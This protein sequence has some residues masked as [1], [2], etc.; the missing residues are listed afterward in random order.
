MNAL[1]LAFA[2]GSFPLVVERATLHHIARWRQA[3]A[4]MIRVS[5]HRLMLEEPLDDPR[6]AAKQR[7]YEAQGLYLA[8]QAEVGYPHYRHIDRDALLSA[9]A[10]HGGLVEAHVER[11]DALLSFDEFFASFGEF[12]ERSTRP[13]HWLERLQALR[14][15]FDGGP[16]CEDDTLT[17]SVAKDV[18]GVPARSRV[19]HW[20]GVH[21]RSNR[22]SRQ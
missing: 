14:S 8:V 9:V 17:V 6:S 12:A 22:S 16:L 5:S 20:E 15:R 13:A 19:K 3:L 4:E 2:S 10:S 11:S 21:G 7:T 1:A 18:Q